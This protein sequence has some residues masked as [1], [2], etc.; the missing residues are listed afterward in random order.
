MREPIRETSSHATRQENARPKSS[1]LGEPLWADPGMNSEISVRELIS[2][3]E[4]KKK[5]QAGNGRTFFQNHRKQ[6]RSHQ[7]DTSGFT[8]RMDT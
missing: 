7:N 5:E 1:Q 3:S 2:T 6:G 8:A 4:K